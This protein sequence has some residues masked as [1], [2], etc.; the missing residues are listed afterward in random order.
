MQGGRK[1]RHKCLV[2]QLQ[3][4]DVIHSNLYIYTDALNTRERISVPTH[5]TPPPLRRVYL[6]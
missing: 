4:L 1:A 5:R 2:L 6:F 3:R